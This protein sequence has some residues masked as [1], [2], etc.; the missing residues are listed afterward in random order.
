MSECSI[1]NPRA[2]FWLLS[3][4]GPLAGLRFPLSEGAT[5]V[6]RAPD[7]HVVVEG[8]NTSTVSLYHIEIS[9]DDGCCRLR[10]LGS[11]NGTWVNEERVSEANITAPATIR[12]GSQGP[13]FSLVEEEAAPEVLDRTIEAPHAELAGSAKTE[14]TESP[15][16]KLLSAAV[17]RAR[18]LRLHGVGGETMNIMRSMVDQAVAQMHRRTHRR[19][20]IV[21]LSLVI[22]LVA[23]SLFAALKITAL[24]RQ[25]SAIDTHIRQIDAQLQKAGE[26]MDTDRLISQLGDY[27]KEGESL[28]QSLLYRISVRGD[29][30]F[31]TGELRSVMAE[32]GAEVYSIPP[33]FIDRV[34]HYIQQDQGPDRPVIAHALIQASGKLQTIQQILRKEELPVDLAYIPLVESSLDANKASAAGAVGPWQF[35]GPTAKAYGLRVDA[36]VDERKDLVKST[37]ATCKYLRDL[38]LDFGTGSSVMLALAAYDSGTLTVKQAVSKTVRDPIKQRNFWYLYRS[39]ALPRETRE[40]VPRVFAAIL[41]GRNPRHFGF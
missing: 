40:Y 13:E 26:G 16:E 41:I 32:F 39:Q 6:G 22:A 4:S 37:Y 12:L 34:N 20:R 11:T 24:R 19:F 10:D 38:I 23:V 21:G 3:R 15:Y 25:K 9:K 17:A 1:A 28:Q 36:Q 27:S 29:S 33:D 8:D 7:N 35:T 30:D 18:R 31:V 5:R 2:K 14:S